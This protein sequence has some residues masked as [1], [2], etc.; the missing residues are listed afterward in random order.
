[1]GNPP[2][3]DPAR[4]WAMPRYIPRPAGAPIRVDLYS[5]TLTRPTEGMR[6][7]MARA[8][9]GDEQK[10]EDPSVN[11]LL[12]RVADLLGKPAAVF[13]PSGTMA[14]QI[15]LAVHCR[16]GDE[17]YCDRT[18]HPLHSEAGGASAIAGAQPRALDGERGVYSGAQLEAALSPGSRYAPRSRLVWVEQT[19]N[20]A[21][22][23]CWG[24]RQ[25][26]DVTEVAGA[27][28]LATHLDGARLLNAVVATGVPASTMASAFDSVWID[29]SKGLGAPVGAA[30]AGSEEFIDEAW[31]WKQRLGGSMRQA[32]VLAA[33]AGYALDHQVE[34]LA[35]DHALARRL[36]TGL[37]GVDGI[38]LDPASVDT[39]I[40][41]FG[42]GGYPGGAAAFTSRLL[43]GH[44]VRAS[45]GS[46]GRVRMVTH[47][48]V[49]AGD[50][51]LAL[52]AVAEVMA[53]AGA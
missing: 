20:L 2:E 36:A 38:E 8:E 35:D 52:A 19:A 1:M 50:V 11:R 16:P 7:A 6:Q 40:V 46:H 5:D 37:A 41:V 31:R 4:P 14:N 45:A 53:G 48:D 39:N 26:K 25:L 42:V 33:A 21:G 44:A 34:R 27:G 10:G 12:E 51:D 9:V 32:G 3:G 23:T 29:F 47:H 28:G 30:L 13:L 49:S 17:F 24:S 43:E 18:A 22:G 15:S